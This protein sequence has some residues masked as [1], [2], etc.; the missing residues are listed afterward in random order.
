MLLSS[1]EWGGVENNTQHKIPKPDRN[2]G[3][4]W[5]EL[6]FPAHRSE[7]GWWTTLQKIYYDI[8]N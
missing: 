7:L 5:I 2:I 6:D 3:K 4:S 1:Q 8:A